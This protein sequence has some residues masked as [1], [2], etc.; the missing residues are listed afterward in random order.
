MRCAG[1]L[2]IVPR[3]SDGIRQSA[4]GLSVQLL[5]QT[6]AELSASRRLL[7]SRAVETRQALNEDGTLLLQYNATEASTFW[8]LTSCCNF[9]EERC[10]C[11]NLV[12]FVAGGN[13][14]VP[15]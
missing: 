3:G 10:I 5:L 14:V 6:P 8:R 7:V 9:L 15:K 11:W 4:E 2:T 12:L 13:Q 1:N